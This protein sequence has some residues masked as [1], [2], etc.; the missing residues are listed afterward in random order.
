MRR[1]FLTL[2]TLIACKDKPSE[3]APPPPPPAP[4]HDGVTL[5]D[6]GTG[7]LQALRYHLTK[8]DK[9]TTELVWDFDARTDGKSDPLPTLVVDLETT[10]DDVLADGSA[11]LRVA[12][13]RTDVRNRPGGTV[14]SDLVR[15]EAAAMQGV[16]L[17]E[18]LAPDGQ[19]SDAHVDA[20]ATLPDHVRARLDSLTR[21][22]AQVAM[23]LP[24]EPVGVNA[25][26]RVRRTLPEGGIRAVSETT[27]T[28]TS[29]AGSALAYAAAGSST[30]EP[31]T[32]EQ[33]GLKVE[34]TNTHGHA[35]THGTVDLSHFA[36]RVTSSSVFA[37][38][39]TVAGPKDA[40]GTGASTV[41]ITMAIQ[42]TPVS[43]VR[44]AAD[45]ATAGA[46]SATPASPGREA[47]SD[48]GAHSAP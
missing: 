30:G 14:G 42:V 47:D 16:I 5:V 27:Y 22:L 40:T 21:S 32:I 12:V 31:Q 44:D 6:P 34:V 18:L 45:D 7:P 15:S 37:T 24:A 17:T 36:P 46:G 10:V 38:A 1:G 20:P 2:V 19:L 8:G 43:A 4:P 39:M 11:R 13:V 35:E 26:W 23:R 28:L 3:P 29:L 25:T 41:E 33:D 9:T 48:Q